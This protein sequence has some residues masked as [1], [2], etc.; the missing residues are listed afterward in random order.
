[1]GHFSTACC[2]FL[3]MTTGAKQFIKMYK[4]EFDLHKNEDV[5]CYCRK[6]SA[7]RIVARHNEKRA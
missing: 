3:K 1:M 6:N 4:Y 5:Y 2:S 7:N